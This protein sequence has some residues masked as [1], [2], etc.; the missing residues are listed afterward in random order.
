VMQKC[1]SN[2]RRHEK[3]IKRLAMK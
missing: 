2:L 1:E 3:E